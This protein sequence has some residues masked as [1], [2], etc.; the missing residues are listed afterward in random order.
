[1]K[2]LYKFYW[3]CGRNGS[4]EGV[5][6]AEESE[7]K[8]AIGKNCYFG[9][10]LGK[11]SEILGVLEKKDIKEITDDKTVLSVITEHLDGG[12]GFNPLDYIQCEHGCIVNEEECEECEGQDSA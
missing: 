3:D 2:K 6:V 7:I 1:M 10:V 12:I 5:F 4:L 8:A 11:H 9:E